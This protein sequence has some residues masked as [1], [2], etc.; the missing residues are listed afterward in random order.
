M[1]LVGR[2]IEA[3]VMALAKVLPDRYRL[4]PRL[5]GEPMLRQFKL[6]NWAYL[7]SFSIAETSDFFHVH[8]WRRMISFVLSGSLMEERYPGRVFKSHAA[9]SIYTMDDTVIH[10]LHSVEPN[11]W[12]LF[13][14]LENQE[15]WG[16]YPRPEDAGYTT[17]DYMIKPKNRVK[18]L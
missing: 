16:Y 18:A 17:W 10:R 11:T 15:D 9:P 2:A 7:Q 13:L 14:M 1:S 3:G 6:T 5:D 4:I 8:R 12:T